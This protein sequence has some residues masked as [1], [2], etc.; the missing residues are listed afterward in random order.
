MR[1]RLVLSA[2][3]LAVLA[4]AAQAAP[5]AIDRSFGRGGSVAVPRAERIDGLAVARGNSVMWAEGNGALQPLRARRGVDDQKPRPERDELV[6]VLADGT[7]LARAAS[8]GKVSLRLYS[9]SG[10]GLIGFGRAGSLDLATDD[11]VHAAI[12]PDGHVVVARVAGGRPPT[13]LSAYTPAGVAD[14][15]FAPRELPEVVTGVAADAAGRILIAG[16]S[17]DRMTAFVRRLLPDGSE[18]PAWPP[19][20]E[21]SEL[22]YL[23]SASGFVVGPNA[24]GPVVATSVFGDPLVFD[25]GG[26]V[27]VQYTQLGKVELDFHDPLVAVDRAGRIAASDGKRVYLVDARGRGVRRIRRDVRHNA[28]A[29]KLE[30]LAVDSRGRIVVGG[31]VAR[32]TR[33]K[34]R[35][36]GVIARMNG[37]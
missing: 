11:T 31:R 24:N 3:L 19:Y 12:R 8:P 36:L 15:A 22:A 20:V 23:F 28:H 6:A 37:G 10:N 16:H 25:S 30:A 13:R 9:Y 33:G 5:G 17:A 7:Q 27:T 32:T 2:L 21:R 34:D 14:P 1:R 26:R 29:L 18:D 35:T 4:P